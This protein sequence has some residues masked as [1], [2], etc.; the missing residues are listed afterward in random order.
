MGHSIRTHTHRAL[1]GKT[2]TWTWTRCVTAGTDRW[3]D[4]TEAAHGVVVDLDVC[5]C[6]AT[7][8]TEANAGTRQYGPWTESVVSADPPCSGYSRPPRTYDYPVGGWDTRR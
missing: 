7:R 1:P 8:A 3:H 2:T 5:R 6:G 4:H